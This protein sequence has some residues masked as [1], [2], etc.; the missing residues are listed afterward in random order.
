SLPGAKSSQALGDA[1]S[2]S[3][4][5]GGTA[6]LKC[7]V[8][9]LN[10]ADYGGFWYHLRTVQAPRWVLVHWAN[11]GIVRGTGYTD[12]FQPSRDAGTSSYVLT[13]TS[14]AGADTGT[15]YC[16]TVKDNQVIFGNGVHLFIATRQPS[17]PT[18]HLYQPPPEQLAFPG[19]DVTLTC[20]ASGFYPGYIR[21]R[22]TMDGKEAE[23]RL[24]TEAVPAPGGTDGSY[25]WSGYLTLTADEWH[26]HSRFSCELH[27]ESSAE[28]VVGTLDRGSCPLS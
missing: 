26:A 11:G 27:H 2:V 5:A 14:I 9:G 24:V 28:P 13:I 17:A 20:L 10:V 3:V 19:H 4:T 1:P 6:A 23:R 21:A 25:S 18:V 22:W 16:A 15:Y 7:Q 8:K 12:R